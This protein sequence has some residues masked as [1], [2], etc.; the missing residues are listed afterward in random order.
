MRMPDAVWRKRA[1]L[2]ALMD[3]L[4]AER[5][6]VRIVGGAVR[7]ALLALPVS[8]VD[9]GTIH[10]PAE[11]AERIARAGFKAVPTGIAHGTITAVLPDGPIEVTTLRRDVETD[12]RHARVAFTDDWHEDAAR[13]D[14]TINALSAEAGSGLIHDHFGGL[15]DLDRR[16]VRFIGD[17][18]QRIA[19]DHLRILRFFR[20]HARFGIGAPEPQGLSACARRANDLMSLSRERIA[21][22][23]LKLLA[24][25]NPAPAL[26]EML[27]AGIL[28]AILPE[29]GGDGLDRL[30]RLVPIERELGLADPLR[31]MSALLPRDAALVDSI[32]A[33]LKLSNAQR[34]R[35]VSASRGELDTSPSLLA[36]E[37]GV[38]GAIDRLLLAGDA[39][40]VASLQGWQPPRLPI[41]G[42][43]L[44]ALGMP[45]GPRIAATLARVERRWASE[46]FPD[47]DRALAI[48]A[49]EAAAP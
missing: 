33:R 41:T 26:A 6:E 28:T 49:E 32:G 15:T 17:P 37:I 27:S 43:A 14:F 10:P 3:A 34:R 4:G 23:L 31:R 36:H 13:R 29:I 48:A 38:Q 11:S 47:R 24:V 39:A 9:L 35:L 30:K 18:L 46:G 8:D 21:Q 2:P 1:G 44:I 16:L 45:A 40:G 42:S 22:E 25:P 7:D 5:D 12:G 19:E 20:F